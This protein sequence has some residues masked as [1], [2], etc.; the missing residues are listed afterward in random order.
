LIYVEC[1]IFVNNRKSVVTTASMNGVVTPFTEA[2]VMTCTYV[3]M[4]TTCMYMYGV[5]NA[6]EQRKHQTCS[7]DMQNVLQLWVFL[8]SV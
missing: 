6:T 2:L 8:S 3:C 7:A 5:H 1:H 4:C